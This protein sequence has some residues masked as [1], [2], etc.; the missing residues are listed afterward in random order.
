MALTQEQNQRLLEL[1]EISNKTPRIA[2]ELF[3][4]EFEY[5]ISE[6]TIKRKC[7]EAGLKL[8]DKG[9]VRRGFDRERFIEFYNKHEGDLGSMIKETGYKKS[10]LIKLCSKHDLER[11]K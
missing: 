2:R 4:E 5:Y 3:K 7:K 9:G 11:P 8:Q 1:F 10:S 6:A